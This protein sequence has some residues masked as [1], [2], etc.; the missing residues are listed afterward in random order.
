MAQ[1]RQNGRWIDR[2]NDIQIV[3]GLV[4]SQTFCLFLD[5]QLSHITLLTLQCFTSLQS[6]FPFTTYRSQ[7]Q[8][9]VTLSAGMGH[10]HFVH[11]EDH[12]SRQESSFMFVW[13]LLKESVYFSLRENS[14]YL[15]TYRLCGRMDGRHD[16]PM[17]SPVV[18]V[19][20]KHQGCVTGHQSQ[21]LSPGPETKRNCIWKKRHENF[22]KPHKC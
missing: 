10:S 8:L 14:S 21:A 4:L 20:H 18:M 12:E 13:L 1:Y 16:C 22:Q 3:L 19:I 17:T 15:D 7:Q 2:Q 9:D 11:F 5:P 6:T